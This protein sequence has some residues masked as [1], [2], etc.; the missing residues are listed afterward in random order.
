V[1]LGGDLQP[2]NPILEFRL[3]QTLTNQPDQLATPNRD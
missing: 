2:I 1:E 3:R